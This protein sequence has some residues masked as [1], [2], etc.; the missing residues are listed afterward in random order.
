M[1]LTE[2]MAGR[3]GWCIQMLL[4]KPTGVSE[5]THRSNY[6][7]ISVPRKDLDLHWKGLSMTQ[8]KEVKTWEKN[9]V[10]VKL[11]ILMIKKQE[12]RNIA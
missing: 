5:E 8:D 6:E 3:R 9:T 12:C 10:K 7:A 1:N 11:V 4:S 2:G